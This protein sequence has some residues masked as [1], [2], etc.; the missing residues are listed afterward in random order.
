[1][2]FTKGSV[3]VFQMS[4]SDPKFSYSWIRIRL[5]LVG[6]IRIRVNF[7]TYLMVLIASLAIGFLAA[8]YSALKKSI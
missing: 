3:S 2:D 8:A 4:D 1:M 5:F 7:T 6:G